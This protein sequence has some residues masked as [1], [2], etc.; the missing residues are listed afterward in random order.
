MNAT[1]TNHRPEDTKYATHKS[2]YERSERSSKNDYQAKLE[3]LRR[4][5][6]RKIKTS[7]FGKMK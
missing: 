2:S 1:K 6:V 4:K 7:D 3:T 5:E